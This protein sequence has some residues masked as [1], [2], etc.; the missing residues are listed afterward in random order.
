[1]LVLNIVFG[2]GIDLAA[3]LTRYFK[4]TKEALLVVLTK[5]GKVF[6]RVEAFLF[7]G[8]IASELNDQ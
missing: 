1:M 6:R 3:K 8:L 2:A 7:I 5:N 4:K